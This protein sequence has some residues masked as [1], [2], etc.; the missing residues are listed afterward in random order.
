MDMDFEVISE[1]AEKYPAIYDCSDIFQSLRDIPAFT[2]GILPE[3]DPVS[4]V[5][6]RELKHLRDVLNVL[7]KENHAEEK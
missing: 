5:S 2:R 3:N 4:S 6:P 1:F 7:E